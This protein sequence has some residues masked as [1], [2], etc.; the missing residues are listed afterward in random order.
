MGF[1]MGILV[2]YKP[3]PISVK[4]VMDSEQVDFKAWLNATE[5][6]ETLT[7]PE[8][9][10]DTTIMELGPQNQNRDGFFLVPNSI[11]SVYGPS[12]QV[13]RLLHPRPLSP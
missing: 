9:P 13:A 2:I 8:G 1:I 5:D 7:N 10:T 12:G 4:Q 6:I 11:G 3:Y